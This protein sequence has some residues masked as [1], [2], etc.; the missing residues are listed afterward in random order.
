MG[1]IHLNQVTKSYGDVEVIPPLDLTIEDGEFTVFVGPSGCGK[2]TLLRM[3]AG[4]EDLT[5]GHISIDGLDAT[6]GITVIRSEQPEFDFI[7][8]PEA[9]AWLLGDAPFAC[10]AGEPR[11]PFSRFI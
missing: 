6:K 1:Q 5:S 7:L 4:L 9:Q 11:C 10:A 8:S 3:I 2:S